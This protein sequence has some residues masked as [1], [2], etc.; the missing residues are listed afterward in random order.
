MA[1]RPRHRAIKRH[2]SYTIE[3]AA[4]ALGLA[5]GTVLR[6][7]RDGTL[8]A[9]K[10]KKPFLI[11]GHDLNAFLASRRT[12]KTPCQPTQCY[13]FTCRAPRDPAGRMGEVRIGLNGTGNLKAICCQC[14]GWM[15]RRVS[16]SQ[17]ERLRMALD[18]DVIPPASD[19]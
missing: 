14:G 13:C 18:V 5:K 9:L 3:E 16:A 1:S 6:W 19:A 15:H 8:A 17:I 7:V 11:T 12:A 2:R 4:R 10:D